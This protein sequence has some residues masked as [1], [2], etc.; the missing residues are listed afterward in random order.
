MNDATRPNA[1]HFA[2]AHLLHAHHKKGN[3]SDAIRSNLLQSAHS[4]HVITQNVDGLSHRA[5]DEF[6]ERYQQNAAPHQHIIEMHGNVLRT[7]CT[8]CGHAQH[9]GDDPISSA[10]EGTEN[11]AQDYQAIPHSDLPRCQQ[12]I[13]QQQICQ[14][15]LRPGVVWFG[16]SIPDLSRIGRLIHECDLI[17][18][19]GTSSTVYPAAGFA[20]QVK[21]NGGQ[22]AVFNTDSQTFDSHED[23]LTDWYFQGP[24][25][26]VLPNILGL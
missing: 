22:V 17:L 4:F 2:L 13:E 18:V 24:V 8:K 5:L 26:Q 6:A 23:G 16:E 15:L 3:S 19:L 1:A 10:L 21:Q 9:N 14:G 20:E 12:T 7:I 25:E 11:L